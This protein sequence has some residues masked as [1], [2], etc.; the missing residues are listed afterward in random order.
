MTRVHYTNRLPLAVFLVS[1]TLLTL[2]T[3]YIALAECGPGRTASYSD[4]DS[5]YVERLQAGGPN[6]EL[7]VTRRGD[8]SFVGRRRV[9]EVGTYDGDD[10]SALFEKLVTIIE[11]HD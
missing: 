7:L 10:G 5:I 11:K 1:A 6:F 2:S 4:V 8:V 3:N 9:P